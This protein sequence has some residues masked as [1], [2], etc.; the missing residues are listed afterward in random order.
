MTGRLPAMR[1]RIVA[2]VIG[3]MSAVMAWAPAAAQSGSGQPIR[4][5]DRFGKVCYTAEGVIRPQTTN[6]TLLNHIVFVRNHCYKQIKL[7]VC[8]YKSVHCID[9]VVPSQS[10]KEGW[11]GATTVRSFEYT[12]QELN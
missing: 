3:L 1:H 5:Y 4:S 6:P 12:L 10:A 11:L 7:K 9:M 8:Y 2:V